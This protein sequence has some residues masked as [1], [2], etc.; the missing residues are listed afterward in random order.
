M[1]LARADWEVLREEITAQ[2][3][4]ACKKFQS[5]IG[6]A[7]EPPPLD[8]GEALEDAANEYLNLFDEISELHRKVH[9][10]ARSRL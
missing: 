7:D 8:L 1:P 9:N 10:R 4:A 3:I 5:A 6:A 2:T